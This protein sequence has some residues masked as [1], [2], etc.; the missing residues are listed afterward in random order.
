M[1]G[2]AAGLIARCVEGVP[3]GGGT[4]VVADYGCSTGR[5]SAASVRAAVSAVRARRPGRP[6]EL[7]PR[8]VGTNTPPPVSTAGRARPATPAP[9]TQ[10]GPLTGTATVG[11]T[12]V[13][14]T[15][16]ENGTLQTPTVNVQAATTGYG[17]TTTTLTATV[18]YTGTTAP[19][20]AISF[21][22]GSGSAVTGSC[23]GTSS[24]LTCTAAYPTASLTISG[25]PYTIT[26][27]LAS[28][29]N[30]T[31]A[32]GTG[33][34]TVT[35]AT[36]VIT[37]PTPAAI[38]YG[39]ALSTT[40]LDAT[41]SYSG[42]TVAGSFAYNPTSGTVLSAGTQK[43]SV[44]FT[45]TDTADYTTATG[46]V[47]LTVNT[48]PLKVTANNATRAYD[49]ANPS[50]T[51]SVTGAVNGD[52]FTESFATTA[53]TTSNA[54]TYPITP[55]VNGTNLSDYTVATTNGALTVT[56]A[57]SAVAL[58]S[59]TK[60]AN[61]NA[62]VT[63][64]DTVT[65]QAGAPTG[66][67]QF[68]DGSTVLGSGQ[69]NSNGVATYSTSSLTAGL[70]Q[71]TA[72]YQGDTDFAGSTSAALA[73]TVTAPDFGLMSNKNSLTL[74]EGQTGQFTISMVPVG[75]F[76]GDV[77]FTCSGLPTLAQCTF[78]PSALTADGSNTTQTSTLTIT[79][80]G[81]ATGTVSMMTH[82]NKPDGIML[83]GIFWL[84][85]LF[86]G[87]FLFWQ[88]K[89]V[90]AKYRVLLILLVAVAT[91]SGTVGCGSPLPQTYTGTAAVF[92]H[93]TSGSSSQV[94]TIRLKITQ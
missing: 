42:S 36:P 91:L 17:A 53:T 43:L 44:T 71:I 81:S 56:K 84:P 40:Q 3:P 27:S 20:G 22:V 66:S 33:S 87:G 64:T 8:R 39:T 57:G 47:S 63:F 19:T 60:N 90:T 62:N 45:P 48:A 11:G 29:S 65:S 82:P 23:S 75:G 24:P 76:K 2:T 46:S 28:D 30:F 26:A 79:T 54:G 92:V 49:T 94:L 15:F 55:S 72:V 35:K 85:A 5:N 6:V 69:V 61:L 80:K 74:K 78:S 41:A 37:W 38:T 32:S 50:F 13:S 21:K 83:A 31:T 77:Q 86:L 93:G 68:L 7:R 1:A 67:V 9:P 4:F 59:S 73:Q 10:G 18:R 51:G 16:S 14:K 25:S 52:K 34:L 88:R 58:T 89:K 70:H 12:S